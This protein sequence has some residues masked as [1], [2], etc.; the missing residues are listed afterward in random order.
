MRHVLGAGAVAGIGF[1]VALFITELAFD[2]AELRDQAKL[3]ILVASVVAGVL[4]WVLF[5]LAP[6]ERDA[7][8][9]ARTRGVEPPTAGGA[10]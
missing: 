3:G 7:S 5:R 10:R 4:G 2:D 1:T 6:S 9:G 8:D